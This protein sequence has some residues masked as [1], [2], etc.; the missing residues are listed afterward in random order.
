MRIR[1]NIIDIKFGQLF[2]WQFQLIAG[3]LL[4][5]ALTLVLEK[6]GLAIFLTLIALFIFSASEGTEVNKTDKTY[7]EYKSLFFMKTGKWEKYTDIEKIFV[8]SYNTTQKMH[9]AYM[10]RMSTFKNVE[11]NG[12][13]KFVDGTK[14]QLLRTRK[15]TPLIE[16]LKAIAKFLQVP[17]E[18]NTELKA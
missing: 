1:E 13:L 11:F 18:D 9:T 10:N 12:Y 2:P 8:N 14:I 3:V 5:V 15:K 6:T 7:R 4:F 17:L 16:S